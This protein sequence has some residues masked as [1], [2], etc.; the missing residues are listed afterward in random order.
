MKKERTTIELR[1]LKLNEGQLDWLP[2]NP[3]QWTK[4]ALSLIVKS[5]KE[6]PDFLEDRPALV[7]PLDGT[8]D[9]VVFAGNF[10]CEGARAA[11]V[12]KVPCIVYEPEDAD[13]RLTVIRRAIKD[14][15][16]YGEWDPDI[17]ANEWDDMP[18]ADW[19]MPSWVTGDRDGKDTSSGGGGKEVQEDDFD[20]DDKG[21]LV[22]CKPGDIWQLGDHRLMC[23]DSTNLKTV[24]TLMG[25]VLANMVITKTKYGVAIGD[26]NKLLNDM[27]GGSSIEKNIEND[28]LAVD[29]LYKVLTK[30]MS[31]VRE[32]SRDDACYFVASMPGGDYEMMMM[33]MMRDAG[34]KVRHQI[35][36][37]KDAATFSLGR[38]DY[39]YQHE[40]IMYTWA[41]SHK[42]HRGGKFRTSVWQIPKP[43]KN[44]LHPTMKPVE[45]VANCILDGSAEGDVVLDAFGGSGTTL[46]AAEQLGRKCYMM[47]LDPH[48]CDV[49]IARWEKL[50][51]KKAVKVAAA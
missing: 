42:N 12:G 31:N 34:L 22:R 5:I 7:V 3:R 39:D 51:G 32:C 33:M 25:G 1:R 44:D 40:I 29:A 24:K 28:T 8:G 35:I 20:E 30:A 47:E 45:L 48:Y 37:A 38:L 41:K 27:N 50:T 19:G 11:K 23:G 26:K 17:L 43:R 16:Q 49:I 9:F 2:R 13:D 21:I 36:W 10:R 4:D 18:L 14:N 46:I 15:G 6:D